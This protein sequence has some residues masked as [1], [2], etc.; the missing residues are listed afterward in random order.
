MREIE[1]VAGPLSAGQED[2]LKVYGDRI[3]ESSRTMNVISRAAVER[4]GEHFVDSAAV[5]SVLELADQDV[6][7]LG[8]GSGLPGVVVAILRPS[9]RVVLLDSRRSKVTFLRSV[10]RE[11]RLPNVEVVHGRVQ[12]MDGARE[13]DTGLSRALGAV[14]RSLGASL[15]LLKE[16]G[17]LVL[18]KGPRWAGEAAVAARIAAREGAELERTVSVDLPGQRRATTFVVFHVK[19]GE[20]GRAG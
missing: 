10:E 20:P 9:A 16:G 13:F 14:E 18:F 3:L 6:V 19:R 1:A 15:R 8:S 5:L 17:R 7:D 4:L 11:L 2:L 12:G